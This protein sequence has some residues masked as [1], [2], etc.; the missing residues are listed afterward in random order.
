ML[1]VEEQRLHEAA[2]PTLSVLEPAPFAEGG[3]H[4]AGGVDGEMIHLEDHA[5][6]LAVEIQDGNGLPLLRGHLVGHHLV[7]GELAFLQ[8]V[9]HVLGEGHGHRD[10]LLE[11]GPVRTEVE[12]VTDG[13]KAV[14]NGGRVHDPADADLRRPLQSAQGDLE[15]G[16]SNG[17]LFTVHLHSN[18]PL[19]I[20]PHSLLDLD[21]QL[22]L[23]LPQVHGERGRVHPGPDKLPL[24][25]PAAPVIGLSVL[26]GAFRAP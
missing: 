20:G 25:G 12:H 19:V 24:K 23:E 18:R 7:V 21:D 4:L 13:L 6:R 9:I 26:E 2:G 5:P 8:G 14:G 11:R 17:A 16:P 22:G 10:G 1:P 15:D 3:G